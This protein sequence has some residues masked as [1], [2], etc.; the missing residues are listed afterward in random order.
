MNCRCL[1][2]LPKL[3]WIAVVDFVNPDIHVYH[4]QS[5]EIH[6][7]WIVEG[8]WDGEFIE[9]KFHQSEN[10]FGSG[11]RIDNGKIY[12]VPSSSVVDRIFYCYQRDSLIVANSL[13][14]LLAI[15]GASLD[16]NHDYWEEATSIFRGDDQYQK[17]Y[18]VIHPD[19]KSFYQV[20]YENIV[21]S[22]GRISY[23]PR[24]K[25]LKKIE[26]FDEYHE[27]LTDTLKK[28]SSN[29]KCPQRQHR[30]DAF[31]TISSGYDSTAV[32]ALVKD[33]GVVIA[34]TAKK[35]NS[36]LPALFKSD[37]TD[38]G[39]PIAQMLGLNTLYLDGCENISEDE[40]FFWAGN[41]ARHANQ[42]CLREIFYHSMFS[43]IQSNCQAAVVFT[44]QSGDKI[45]N[46]NTPDSLISEH[47]I[48][49]TIDQNLSEIRLQ[50][51]LINIPVPFL[52]VRNIK[53]IVGISRSEV[54]RPWRLSN[55]YD[56]PIPRRI[57]ETAGVK[58]GTFALKKKGAATTLS[59]RYPYNKTLRK[60]FFAYLK[61]NHGI[62]PG[63]V[64]VHHYLNQS[65]LLMQKVLSVLRLR[66]GKYKQTLFWKDI[67]LTFYLWLWS[68]DEIRQKMIKVFEEVRQDP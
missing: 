61:N 18:R 27:K 59:R 36:W 30:V 56:R 51:G 52:M 29:Y 39:T 41:Y 57:A 2:G 65:Q 25:P 42:I 63:F 17:E 23:E 26:S 9:G 53:D 48:R 43:H 11:V 24:N 15:T 49:D 4:G 54:M 34:F 32:S 44:G 22:K 40:L 21:F 13:I 62:G 55:D 47:V 5:V 45:W 28:I 37:S 64:Y 20:Y 35:S 38:D 31:T 60:R 3:S 1:K 66:S 16:S 50:S 68:V 46:I 7:S 8:V 6:D 33:I 19:I 14:N 10:F 12:F 67:D 58:R